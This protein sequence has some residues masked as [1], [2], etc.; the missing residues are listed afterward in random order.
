MASP[1]KGDETSKETRRLDCVADGGGRSGG[2][3]RGGDYLKNEN[4]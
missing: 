4:L 1:S 3:G 2:K